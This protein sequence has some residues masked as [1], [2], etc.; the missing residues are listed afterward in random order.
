MSEAIETFR[1]HREATVPI[2]TY[3]RLHDAHPLVADVVSFKSSHINHLTPRTLDIDAVQAAM[4][5]SGLPAKTHVEGPPRTCPILLRQTSFR[6]LKEEI[7]FPQE[8]GSVVNGG[9][10]ARF[11]EVEQRGVA[12]T[13]KGRVLY[14]RI[15]ESVNVR[16][17]DRGAEAYNEVVQDAFGRFPTEFADLHGQGLAFARYEA[18]GNKRC[19]TGAEPR[20]SIPELVA[21]GL[22]SCKPIVYEDF[23]PVSAAGIFQSNLA[24]KNEGLVSGGAPN[25]ELFEEHLGVDVLDEFELYECE[26]VRSLETSLALLRTGGMISS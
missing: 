23:L 18:S 15:I 17:R 6:A 1:W 22:L 11:G 5:A 21:N 2:D 9:H 25:R 3:R 20:A 16:M 7:H 8:D 4:S 26:Q 10:T 13:R 19:E 14:D 24:P 12:L